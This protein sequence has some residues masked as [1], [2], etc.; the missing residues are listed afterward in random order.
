MHPVSTSYRH[1]DWATYGLYW[2]HRLTEPPELQIGTL[3]S[4]FSLTSAYSVNHVHCQD[5]TSSLHDSLRSSNL[6]PTVCWSLLKQASAGL[7]YAYL[8]G[9]QVDRITVNDSASGRDARIRVGF[10]ISDGP[11]YF[12]EAFTNDEI[13]FDST[14]VLETGNR[15]DWYD[16][17]QWRLLRPFHT[18]ERSGYYPLSDA[19]Y[20]DPRFRRVLLSLGAIETRAS[21]WYPPPGSSNVDLLSYLGGHGLLRSFP[22]LALGVSHA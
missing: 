4:V 12:L 22:P 21:H 3:R 16:L 2:I 10:V 5:C 13:P 11:G 14:V 6:D 18:H 7:R 20:V 9:L 8:S 17:R 19:S 1:I 15:S